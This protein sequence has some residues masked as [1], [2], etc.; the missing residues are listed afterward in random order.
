MHMKYYVIDDVVLLGL[1]NLSARVHTHCYDVLALDTSKTA[2]DLFSND[3]SRLEA[4]GNGS[5]KKEGEKLE[6]MINAEILHYA[7]RARRKPVSPR[8]CH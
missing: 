8:S 2:A 6:R 5:E 4:P 7:N 3:F 1:L